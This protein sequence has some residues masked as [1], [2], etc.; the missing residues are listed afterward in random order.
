MSVAAFAIKQSKIPHAWK[1]S[2][3][4]SRVSVQKNYFNT[5]NIQHYG[6]ITDAKAGFSIYS[7]YAHTE[8]YNQTKS[9]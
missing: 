6:K 2:F 5:Y 3:A 7:R 4:N 1:G 9:N 8:R